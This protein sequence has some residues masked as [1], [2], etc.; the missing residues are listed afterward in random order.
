LKGYSSLPLPFVVQVAIESIDQEDRATLDLALHL[1]MDGKGSL[2]IY[3]DYECGQTIVRAKDFCELEDLVERLQSDLS[4]RLKVGAPQ[5]AYRENLA[6]KTDLDFTYKSQSGGTGQFGRIKFTVEPGE[7]GQGVIFRNELRGENIPKQ[8][9][10]SIEKGVRQAA[11][12]G[13]LIG[14]PIVDFTVT[15]YDG[16]YH[17]VDSSART[18]EITGRRGMREAAIKAG[19]KLLEPIMKIVVLTHEY[20]LEAVITD[21]ARRRAILESKT[22]GSVCAVVAL[23]PM[24]QLFGYNNALA[25]ATQGEARSTM[26]Y[27]HY[28]VV[29]TSVLPPDEPLSAVAALRA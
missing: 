6:S 15:L 23:V 11:A 27:D 28:G 22:I 3:E 29:P 25:S 13:S 16:A 5:V 2:G 7:C 14:F 24:A 18:F 19:I 9:I 21:L 4:Q 8:Y 12:E 20:W 17:D 1:F 10:P 26:L